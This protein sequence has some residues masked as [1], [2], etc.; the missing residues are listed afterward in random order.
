MSRT[1]G[2]AAAQPWWIQVDVSHPAGDYSKY[3]R[4]GLITCSLDLDSRA[5]EIPYDL[6][7]F[8]PNKSNKTERTQGRR[9]NPELVKCDD[10]DHPGPPSLQ[11]IPL[12]GPGV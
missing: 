8:S 9:Q 5:N 3:H 12:K 1:S 10:Q 7:T 2:A 4:L 6:Y 11:S